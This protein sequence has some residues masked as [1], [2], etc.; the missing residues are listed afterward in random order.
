MRPA[1][2]GNDDRH[3]FI[4]EI[5]P[6]MRRIRDQ[7]PAVRRE[8]FRRFAEEHVKTIAAD[9]D[10][11]DFYTGLSLDG[12]LIYLRWPAEESAAVP[13]WEHAL[14][15]TGPP[16]GLQRPASGTAGVQPLACSGPAPDR[17]SPGP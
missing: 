7:L 13:C 3:A 6:I 8:E 12:A 9:L 16:L 14:T 11:F 5:K 1:S 2:D 15:A 17:P 4:A 10:D